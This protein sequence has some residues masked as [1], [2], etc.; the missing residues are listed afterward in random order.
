MRKASRRP[1]REFLLE[2]C[3]TIL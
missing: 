3:F 2:E 1:T